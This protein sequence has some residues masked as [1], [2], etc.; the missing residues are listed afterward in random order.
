[1]RQSSSLKSKMLKPIIAV[2]AGVFVIAMVCMYT[3]NNAQVNNLIHDQEKN[4]YDM[5]SKRILGDIDGI[6]NKAKMALMPIVNNPEIQKAFAERDRERLTALTIGTWEQ[7]K[8]E[9][10]EQFQFHDAPAIA[11]LRLHSLE[12]YGDDLSS[13]RATVVEAN[14]SKALM[15]GLEEGKGGIGFRVVAPMFMDGKYLNGSVEYGMSLTKDLLNKWKEASGGEVFFYLNIKDS[16]AWDD[17]SKQGFLIGTAEKDSFNTKSEK[18]QEIM[19]GGK[20]DVISEGANTAI[21]IPVKDFQ[22]K[23]I[24][25]VKCNFD[26]TEV[27]KQHSKIINMLIIVFLIT[28]V[29]IIIATYA[30]LSRILSPMT[31]LE[32]NL[33]VVANGDL[34]MDF[35][36]TSAELG[37]LAGPISGMVNNLKEIVTD[38]RDNATNL[39]AYSE[40]LSANAEETSAIATET[41]ATTANITLTV[42][43]T[44]QSTQTM[45]EA[46]ID[47]SREAERGQN[48]IISVTNQMDDI[49]TATNNIAEVVKQLNTTAGKIGQIIETITSIAEQTNLLALNAAIE[50]ARAGDQGRGFAVVAEEVRKLAEGSAEAA[51]EITALVTEIQNESERSVKVMFE[52]VDKVEQGVNVVNETGKSFY[53]IIDKVQDLT[54]KIEEITESAQETCNSISEVAKSAEESTAA[55]QE[56]ASSVQLFS[57]LAERL[58]QITSKF[59]V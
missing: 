11:F 45:K 8:G 55:M 56:V 39:A 52:S 43:K 49:S 10:V 15:V 2:I 35:T 38:I 29:L 30:I 28:F 40:E 34:T 54:S 31:A 1:M 58:T 6:S 46:I 53:N 41:S 25:Y 21:I 24:A 7:V 32:K 51:R 14:K 20:W 17:K 12:K 59:R 16:V 57:Q 18:V 19:A 26:R 36:E 48:N 27:I 37:A 47:A 33:Q 4:K 23:A 5:I 22:G 50:A 42:E 44:V 3:I 9:G 13:F